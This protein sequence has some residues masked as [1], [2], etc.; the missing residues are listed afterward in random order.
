MQHSHP[1]SHLFNIIMHGKKELVGPLLA[2]ADRKLPASSTPQWIFR[3]RIWRDLR[4][5]ELEDWI[6]E[7]RASIPKHPQT[8]EPVWSDKFFPFEALQAEI[9]RL[10]SAYPMD[11]LQA[12][13][14]GDPSELRQALEPYQDEASVFRQYSV[15]PAAVMPLHPPA[16]A[17]APA[18]KPDP[19]ACAFAERNA[20]LITVVIK[21]YGYYTKNFSLEELQAQNDNGIET[22]SVQR[23]LTWE[24]LQLIGYESL[25]R[26][27]PKYDPKR[28]A[29]STFA[30]WTIRWAITEAFKKKARDARHAM[31]M[32]PLHKV[33]M[34]Y[35]FIPAERDD[36]K[37]KRELEVIAPGKETH[38]LPEEMSEEA[39]RALEDAIGKL[40]SDKQREAVAMRLGV[41][42]YHEEH[43]LREIAE[44]LHISTARA[45][46]L[47]K[48]GYAHL[49]KIPEVAKFKE[50]L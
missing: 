48:T 10:K 26:A 35:N 9:D 1:G 25:V 21:R 30:A 16:P 37:D 44:A 40:Q 8:G 38:R 29:E 14:S 22:P 13:K 45:D 24:D 7:Q 43:K 41:L 31:L 18:P 47:I 28:G 32:A 6:Q 42:N 15:Q 33:E 4:I 2:D 19:L 11:W 46:Q 5:A 17:P 49:H 20:P 39:R 12:L 23:I 27:W 3:L 50:F 36:E 34:G